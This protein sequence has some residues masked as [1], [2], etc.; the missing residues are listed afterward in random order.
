MLQDK[1]LRGNTGTFS[2]RPRANY[3]HTMSQWYKHMYPDLDHTRNLKRPSQSPWSHPLLPLSHC[4][5][6]NTGSQLR[7]LRLQTSEVL[8]SHL[9]PA[10]EKLFHNI[11]NIITSYGQNSMVAS[12]LT[13]G[14]GQFRHHPVLPELWFPPVGECTSW[15]SASLSSSVRLVSSPWRAPPLL[16]TVFL[17]F[18]T[19]LYNI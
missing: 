7:L 19:F 8:K 18:S 12:Y 15:R 13:G 14:K 11:S 17:I 2:W 16:S 6:C 4:S 1:G 5:S 9:N 3:K 10:L